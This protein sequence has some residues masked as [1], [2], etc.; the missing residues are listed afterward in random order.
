MPGIQDYIAAIAGGKVV[1]KD[2]YSHA[3]TLSDITGPEDVTRFSQILE[4]HII[5][6]FLGEDKQIRLYQNDMVLITYLFDMARREPGL[7]DFFQTIYSGWKGELA[8]T[9]TKD[10]IERRLQATA[11]KGYN[12]DAMQGY[13][14]QLAELAKQ[15]QDLFNRVFGPKN[16]QQQPQQG[17][18]GFR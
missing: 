11:G 17:Q 18:G 2:P 8:L 1:P 5:L 15:E 14:Q 6:S 9:R 4:K 3:F 7:K 13:G 10:G 16:Q 12:P